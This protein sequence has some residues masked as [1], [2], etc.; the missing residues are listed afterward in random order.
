MK[1]TASFPQKMGRKEED[2]GTPEVLF[3]EASSGRQ[4]RFHTAPGEIPLGK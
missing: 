4:A 3:E 2:L 1:L